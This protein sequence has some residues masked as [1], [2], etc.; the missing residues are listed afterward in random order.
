M[1]DQVR[2]CSPYVLWVGAVL[3]QDSVIARPAASPAGNRWQVEMIEALECFAF[4]CRVISHRPEPRWPRGDLWVS[5]HDDTLPR[6]V[7]G[8]LVS[9]LNVPALK[10]LHVGRQIQSA[11]RRVVRRFGA[12]IA[13]ITYNLSPPLRASALY[14]KRTWNVPWVCVVADALER[15][16]D[17]SRGRHF[18]AKAD[19]VAFLAWRVFER[20][21]H[22][23]RIHLDGGVSKIR[24]VEE[25]AHTC[26]EDVQRVVYT[27]A[28]TKWG[29]VDQLVRAFARVRN[30]K[31]RLVIC[32]KGRSDAVERAAKTD[33]RVDFLGMVPQ[34][35]LMQVQSE[36]SVF[37][38]PRPTHLLEN[39]NNFP[40]KVL[41][42]LSYGK[43]V[44][45]TWT[46]GLDP[47]YRDVLLVAESDEAS[48]ARQ[49]EQALAMKRDERMLLQTRI[50]DFIQTN[51]AWEKQA[52]RFK[53]W[54][55]DSFAIES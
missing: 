32:G 5:R 27:G 11:M 35:R 7:H 47:A 22:P 41:V 19:G 16:L 51:R 48:L 45:S 42:Y 34:E 12:P 28:L 8:Q 55:L 13:T 49:I 20:S 18:Y 25:T 17:E 26:D 30:T 52:T 3:G 39:A 15:S 53:M 37:V 43:P 54:L 24:C 6:R 2:K 4:P 36:A 9:Y 14:A 1:N 46:G 40:S 23:R 31:A 29:G 33:K 21:R 10:Q 50:V 44:V 38:N